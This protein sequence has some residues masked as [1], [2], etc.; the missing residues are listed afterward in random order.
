LRQ[1][2]SQAGYE[3]VLRDYSIEALTEKLLETLQANK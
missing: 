3:T 1:A 2:V